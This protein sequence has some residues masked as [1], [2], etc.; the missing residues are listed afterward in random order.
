MLEDGNLLRKREASAFLD[1]LKLLEEMHKRETFKTMA[2][3]FTMLTYGARA[4]GLFDGMELCVVI[5]DHG[6][7]NVLTGAYVL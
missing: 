1:A 5:L 6:A 4:R 2:Q 7:H 3:I